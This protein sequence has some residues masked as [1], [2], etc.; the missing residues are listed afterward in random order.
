[1]NRPT[2][3]VTFLFTD[4]AAS[5]RRW[6]QHP[7]W[8][9]A[10]HAR[11]EAILRAAIAAHGGWAY[12]QI[13]DG[14]QAAFQTAPAALA[15]AVAAQ[16]ALTAEPWGEPGPLAVR[17]ALHTGTAEERPD[18]YVGPLLNR[19]ARLLAAGH[20][21]QI[22]LTAATTAALGEGLPEGVGLR[23]LG[24]RRLKDLIEPEHIRQA[25]G[26][27]LPGTF[28]P[29][30]TLDTRPNNLPAQP[31]AF[32]GRESQ[33]PELVACL[34]R[35]DSRVL[36]LT[37]PGGTGKTRLA[38]QVAAEL[39]DDFADG[40][41]FVDLAPLTSADFVVPTIAR[42]LRLATQGASPILDRL[43]AF[44]ASRHL[45]LVLDN[46]EQVVTAAEA[47]AGLLVEA[48][49]LT[50]LAT[51]R[52]PLQIDGERE[53][54]IPPLALPAA[55]SSPPFGELTQYEAVR[56][57][58]ARA[59]EPRP[60][61]RVTP[62]EAPAVA[63]IC[64]RLDGLPLAIEL[65]AARVRT[66]TPQV[67]LR[68]LEDRLGLLTDGPRDLPARQQ[69]LRATIGWSYDLLDARAQ[70]LFRQLAVFVGGAPL[71]AVATVCEDGADRVDAL[72]RQSLVRLWA[73]EGA[74]VR[75]I[76][77]ET[78]REFAWEQLDHCGEVADAQARHGA[79][80]LRLA[81]EAV[82]NLRRPEER[83][84][85]DRLEAD[86]DNLR[87]VLDR[88]RASGAIEQELQLAGALAG[89]WSARGY[90]EEAF[91]RL[92][93]ALAQLPRDD[94]PSTPAR[95]RAV[96]WA[97]Y[98]ALRMDRVELAQARGAWAVVLYRAL[99]D[100]RGEAIAL[101]NRGMAVAAGSDPDSFVA[102][103]TLHRESL[104]LFRELGDNWGCGAALLQLGNIAAWQG[105]D[106]EATVLFEQCWTLLQGE[107]DRRGAALAL[108]NLAC[109]ALHRGDY[110]AGQAYLA[111][112]LKD[113]RVLGDK[114]G[115]HTA[116][117]NLG[118]AAEGSGDYATAARYYT[119]CLPLGRELGNQPLVAETQLALG[120]VLRWLGRTDEARAALEDAL[121]LAPPSD[122]PVIA[123]AVLSSL[124]Y[125]S[126]AQADAAGAT[127]LFR[128]SLVLDV[129]DSLH[130]E[131]LRADALAGLAAVL[132]TLGAWATA[133]QLLAAVAAW[134]EAPPRADSVPRRLSGDDDRTYEQTV[135]AARTHLP[136]PAF[137]AAWATGYALSL[138]E[139]AAAAITE[140]AAD[141]IAS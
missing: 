103:V 115:V 8:M 45:L 22:L 139:A 64:A 41:W 75:V 106:A 81:E 26:A 101:L 134:R 132:G 52:T 85:L 130:P 107:G 111:D 54:V 53:F 28:P 58:V 88:A 27:G 70:R 96:E 49:G 133:T 13:G 31:N 43:Q 129:T 67:L 62:A 98:M 93:A 99:G 116:L 37:G 122:E 108:N 91:A 32:I 87:A 121:A 50:V 23:N 44:L 19:V 14:F 125:I 35:S 63:A 131:E 78:T 25:V 21:G 79:Y 11:H 5:T 113:W 100:R 69:T 119:E 105:D 104:A 112:A 84:W 55:G 60:D 18:D 71:D 138:H 89:F 40:C 74:A 124:G 114:G 57:F 141:E 110:V 127:H 9:A 137:Q 42:A 36:T 97:A 2:G 118:A 15:A 30:K 20:G 140:G 102:G 17:M 80:F 3:T 16:R 1:M 77:L 72:A 94:A 65:A 135:V 59:Q 38:L 56:L 117:T 83:L 39:L 126:A 123:A 86:H 128:K 47:I 46:F 4:V 68:H 136:A 76:V 48:P 92:E 95:A 66:H 90:W 10:A 109:V 6:E 34:R 51:S 29:L 12:K 61:F 7:A 24:T 82:T 73:P 120:Q 33:I